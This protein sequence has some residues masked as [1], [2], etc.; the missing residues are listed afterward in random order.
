MNLEYTYEKLSGKEP[1]MAP[2]TQVLG[3]VKYVGTKAS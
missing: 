1:S 3:Q 2:Y